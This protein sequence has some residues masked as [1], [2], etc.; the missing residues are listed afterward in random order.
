LKNENFFKLHSRSY[1]NQLREQ[2]VFGTWQ[3]LSFLKVDTRYQ[4]QIQ[5]FSGLKMRFLYRD[6]QKYKKTLIL[7]KGEKLRDFL[8]IYPGTKNTFLVLK[9]FQKFWT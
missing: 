1:E 9:N 4:M 3:Y 8:E 2:P 5:N 7:V 6:I